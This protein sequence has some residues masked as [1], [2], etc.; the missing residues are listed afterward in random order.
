[1]GH[2]VN[3]LPKT[4]WMP[5]GLLFLCL[6]GVGAH[7]AWQE[8]SEGR[9]ILET[10]PAKDLGGANFKW[11]T[12]EDKLGRLIA[13]GEKL[14]VFDGQSWQ[15][16]PVTNSH[17]LK[18]LAWGDDGR[19]WAGAFNEVGYFAEPT[20]GNFEYRSLLEFLPQEARQFGA[21]WGCAPI[22]HDAFFFCQDRVLRWDGAVFKTWSYPGKVRIFPLKIGDEIWFHHPETGLYR[23]AADGP[24]LEVP[25]ARLMNSGIMGLLRDAQGL[26]C[27]SVDGIYR[28]GNPP[29]RI[30][31]GELTKYLAESRPA[32]FAVLPDGNM[33]IGT[34]NGGLALVDPTG[35]LVR[36]LDTAD[37]LP[38]RSIF[39]I[40]PESSGAI[41]C[42]TPES[43]FR[44]QA[45]GHVTTYD[46]ANGLKGGVL[47]A[48][49]LSDGRFAA[50]TRE[51]VFH[52]TPTSDKGGH[53]ER[54]P[55]LAQLYNDLLPCRGGLMLARHGGVDLFD[56]TTVRQLL[57]LPAKTISFIQRSRADPDRFYLSGSD[58]LHLL[59]AQPDGSFAH[60]RL[61][62]LPDYCT[63]LYE[64]SGK[65]L[66]IG[67]AGQGVCGYDPGAK[68]A[69]PVN[70]P[71]TGKPFPGAAWVK[72]NDRQILVFNQ[73]R[74]LQAAA[75]GS[76]LHP[77]EGIPAIDYIGSRSIPG[78]RETLIVFKHAG[79]SDASAQGVGVLGF[80]K[81]GKPLWRELEVPALDTVGFINTLAFSTENIHPVLWI[82]GSEG[83]LRVDYDTVSNLKNPDTPL[84]RLDSSRSSPTVEQ[85]EL[86]F[87]FHGHRLGFRVFT[88]D[89][90]RG[91]DWLFQT[92]LGRATGE[93]S[94]P[95]ARRSYE[96]TNL[97]EGEYHFQVRAI[98]CAGAASEPAVFAF[99]ILPPWYRAGWAFAGYAAG[100]V[101]LVL[102]LIRYRE[103]RIL[104]RNQELERQVRIRTEE[105]VKASA[106]KDEF[107][108]GVSHEIRN[109]MNGVIG[110]AASLRTD[111]LDAESRRK[112][113][114]LR[115][116]ATHLASLLEDILDLSRVQAGAV[117]LESK[118]FV[119]A[120]LVQ[121]VVAMTATE[122]ERRGIPVEIAIS[123]AVPKQLTGDPRRIRQILL[124]FVGN[125]LKFSGRGKV[126]VTVWCKAAGPQ[127][128]E[129]IFAVSD[130][131]PGIAPEEQKRLFTR[132]ERGAAAR[133]GR[134]PGTGLGLALS[135]GLAE[136]MGGRIWLESEPGQGSCFYF[137]APFAH[138]AAAGTPAPAA[139]PRPDGPRKTALVVD[140]KEY[141][142]IVLT[143]F[144]ESL[145]YRVHSAAEGH[146]ALTLAGQRA[147]D[148]AFLDFDLPGLSGLEIARGIRA[149]PNASARALIVATT[150]FTTEDKRAQCRDA[151]MNTFLGKP[152]TLERLR[153][154]LAPAA[155][156]GAAVAPAPVVAPPT[157]D[158]L[159]NMRLIAARKAVPL[160]D[161]LALY[162]SEF[163][164]ELE[165]LLA[166]LQHED[167]GNTSHYT[168]LLYG[169]CSFIY[170]RELEQNL[171]KIAA[172]AAGDEWDAARSLGREV[173]AQFERLRA[174]LAATSPTGPA[175]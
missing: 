69:S 84:I 139:P 81:S 48:V 14:H 2:S 35:A 8:G 129:V 99:R 131:G 102:G 27:I 128:T 61:P 5:T 66:W 7:G 64:G 114:L 30:S 173:Q 79:S 125:A 137:C 72:G 157:A 144:L 163:A 57:T 147:F 19:L 146:A 171:R 107:L 97:S 18:A 11:I 1:M 150:A 151:G 93:W 46:A 88:G 38:S 155:P 78:S 60:E 92:R 141:N 44:L 117:E 148:V 76:G 118:E 120:D 142:R 116:C 126:S 96:F 156:N 134:V 159:A 42:T 135:K 17:T 65:K 90:A 12:L 86:T 41:W 56:G 145:G 31:N 47:A 122:S 55:Q 123:P 77:L 91:K 95:A 53:F 58:G 140:D 26:V 149:L 62:E 75:D 59:Q 121:A 152:V 158:P 21:V 136:K 112:F 82:G 20:V 51:G 165:Q 63:S 40:R 162:V 105:L 109:P 87:P 119:L 28:P 83:L 104:A 174:Q 16:F 34:L 33:A 85:G 94:P 49:F 71:T 106:A 168:H 133:Q 115:Q 10:V 154:T 160:A 13:G 52:L 39:S 113:G 74:I 130:E 124:N 110:I 70:D 25:A 170:E 73:A 132:F 29:V 9:P 108:A 143:D 54:L 23:V 100:L 37:G 138:V 166:A 153:Q 164:V 169:R 167:A 80:D 89:Y 3:A 175:A 50:L 24:I 43:I 111:A 127:R 98:N 101:L 6:A 68:H 103:R 36:I 32:S 67:T 161:E 22:G 15:A 172:L 45:T 4:P